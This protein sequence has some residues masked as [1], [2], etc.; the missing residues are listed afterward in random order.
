MSDNQ[1]HTDELKAKLQ[2]VLSEAEETECESLRKRRLRA[3]TKA[4][5]ARLEKELLLLD[6][7]L[8]RLLEP[9]AP[10]T[11]STMDDS[12][13]EPAQ[14]PDMTLDDDGG[15]MDETPGVSM[16][17]ELERESP[18]RAI[19]P[20]IQIDSGEMD[21][22]AKGA[23]YRQSLVAMAPPTAG[24]DQRDE[25]LFDDAL[26]LFRLGDSE[27]ALVSLE[28]LL[29]I[30]DLNDD[31]SEFIVANEARLVDLYEARLGSFNAVPTLADDGEPMPDTFRA[32]RKVVAVMDAVDG[33]R[34][35]DEVL[36]SLELTRLEGVMVLSQL[37]RL[38]SIA[39]RDA[40]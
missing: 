22:A 31:L 34:T 23:M 8:A 4:R 6:A 15:S 3:V 1:P 11:E 13:I 20:V 7:V 25:I 28:R 37:L 35:Y 33:N 14:T 19:T 17:V 12:S 26:R 21:V 40:V 16:D 36:Q 10:M 2:E 27:G 29:L 32:E 24:W 30:S 18:P 38:G 39:S 5:R 9:A